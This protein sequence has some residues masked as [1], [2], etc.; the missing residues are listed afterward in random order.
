MC[1]YWAAR[2]VIRRAFRGVLPPVFSARTDTRAESASHDSDMRSSG[3][4]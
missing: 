4:A 3:T 2:S 1:G